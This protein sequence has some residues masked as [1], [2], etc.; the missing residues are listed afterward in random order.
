M[1]SADAQLHI[2]PVNNLIICTLSSAQEK[3]DVYLAALAVQ[4]DWI[5]QV[6][7]ILSYSINSVQLNWVKRQAF[8]VINSTIKFNP[9]GLNGNRLWHLRSTMFNLCLPIRTNKSAVLLKLYQAAP[10]YHFIPPPALSF[11]GIFFILW[12]L[13]NLSKFVASLSSSAYKFL[14]LITSILLR[15]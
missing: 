2:Y 3:L 12:I 9:G 15:S 4:L 8:H 11:S 5:S 10:L 7:C 6:K 1:G 14:R 13:L